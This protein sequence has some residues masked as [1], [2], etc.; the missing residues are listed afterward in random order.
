MTKIEV[1]TAPGCGKCGKAKHV[2]EDI[3]RQMGADK[4]EWRE[5]NILQ[6]MD[7]AIELGVLSTPAIAI[8]GKLVF[9]ALPSAR[10]LQQTLVEYCGEEE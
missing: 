9:S 2:L 3:A 1:F 7:Y 5:V 10:Q 4:F 8:Q 6:E